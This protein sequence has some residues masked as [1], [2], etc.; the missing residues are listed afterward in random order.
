MSTVIKDL[1]VKIVDPS[2]NIISGTANDG[3]IVEVKIYLDD[4][5]IPFHEYPTI[6]AIANE[7]GE[8][9][10]EFAEL[11]ESHNGHAIIFDENNNGTIEYWEYNEPLSS[12]VGLVRINDGVSEDQS[13][14]I[15]TADWHIWE[16]HEVMTGD[17]GRI[18]VNID[19]L[20][21]T[22]LCVTFEELKYVIQASDG[23]NQTYRMFDSWNLLD[24]VEF[25]NEVFDHENID[26]DYHLEVTA[27]DGTKKYYQISGSPL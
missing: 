23:S 22:D 16:D 24:G 5:S 20:N 12:N 18:T 15:I 2:T 13:K 25:A 9:E 19:L 8:W 27:E 1:E 10:V 26:A 3:D 6:E 7:H 17:R 4:P 21:C 14:L 11:E